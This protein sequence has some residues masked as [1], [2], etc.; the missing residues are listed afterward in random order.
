MKKNLG[1]VNKNTELLTEMSKKVIFPLLWRCNLC[2]KNQSTIS[3][4]ILCWTWWD[5]VL[6][7]SYPRC[8]GTPNLILIRWEMTEIW[9]LVRFTGQ[10][11]SFKWGFKN[12]SFYGWRQQFLSAGVEKITVCGV[13]SNRWDSSSCRS[14]WSPR[15]TRGFWLLFHFNPSRIHWHGLT[16]VPR[17][18]L[19]NFKVLRRPWGR[20][21]LMW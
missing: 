20:A 11:G 18:L 13:K 2:S 12:E 6:V 17:E 9:D 10:K 3:R 1:V 16:V 19:L 15:W 14:T 5:S 4:P 21:Y 8:F 7:K